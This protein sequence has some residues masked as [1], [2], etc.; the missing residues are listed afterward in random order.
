MSQIP[1]SN[2]PMPPITIDAI[3]ALVDDAEQRSAS[4]NTIKRPVARARLA[5][6]WGVSF[7]TLTNFRRGRLKDLR[8]ATRARIQAGI[9]RGIEHEIQRLEH[10]LVVVR[11]CSAD[12]SETNIVQASVALEQ[13]RAF[14]KGD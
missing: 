10:E 11:Q 14:L 2:E 4:R 1:E 13:A 9:V 7:W 8:S 3:R 5:N 6:S 12:L